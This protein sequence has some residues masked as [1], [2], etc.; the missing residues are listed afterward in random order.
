MRKIWLYTLLFALLFGLAACSGESAVSQSKEE[1]QGDVLRI[2]Y[3]NSTGIKEGE[4]PPIGGGE[5]WAIYKGL[6]Q[7]RLAKIGITKIEYYSFPNGPD[8]NEAIAAGEI[9]IGLLGDTPGIL[10]KASGYET[11]LLGLSGIKSNLWLVSNKKE[12][13]TDLSQLEGKIVGTAKGS[14]MYRY[15]LG[16]LEEHGLQDKV[17]VVHMLPPDAQTSLEKGDIAAYAA[18]TY[19]GPRLVKNG[20]PVIHEAAK[21]APHLSGTSVTIARN[22]FLEKHPEFATVWAKTRKEAVRDLK[23]NLEEY[24]QYYSTVSQQDLDIVKDSAPIDTFNEDSFP[25]EGLALLEGTKQFLLEQGLI[26]QDFSIEDWRN[27]K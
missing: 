16:L 5:G 19:T 23:Q 2:G 15:L 7:E 8:L 1:K 10:A 20:F 25:E 18:P 6:L 24:Y 14:Y 4:N 26:R 22:E 27:G 3:I 17:E 12:V 21:D 11:T 13:I 9:D